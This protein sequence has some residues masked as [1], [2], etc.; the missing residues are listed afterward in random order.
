MNVMS[1]HFTAN[2]FAVD[3]SR[4]DDGLKW[5]MRTHTIYIPHAI[6]SCRQ[7]TYTIRMAAD[8]SKL[9][10]RLRCNRL[11]PSCPSQL[12]LLNNSQ[13][14]WQCVGQAIEPKSQQ[15]Q[16]GQW[17]TEVRSS[18]VFGHSHK[19]SS[20]CSFFFVWL[21]LLLWLLLYQL[22]FFSIATCSFHLEVNKLVIDQ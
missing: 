18:S 11:S 16:L 13:Q 15:D 8:K 20:S 6:G 19:H 10:K 17:L 3:G 12:T 22:P 5:L 7:I 1:S 4:F 21:L 14:I 2:G 9:T